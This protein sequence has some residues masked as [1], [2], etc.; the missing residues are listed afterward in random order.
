MEE[1][2]LYY[3]IENNINYVEN[4]IYQELINIMIDWLWDNVLWKDLLKILKKMSEEI[5]FSLKRKELKT[6]ISHSN[7]KL[8]H[9]SLKKM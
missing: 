3:Y 9:N 5:Y 8:Y 4:D 6:K 7:S 2:K 1:S